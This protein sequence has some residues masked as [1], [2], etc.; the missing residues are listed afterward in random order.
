MAAE[1]TRTKTAQVGSCGEPQMVALLCGLSVGCMCAGNTSTKK[2]KA[3]TRLENKQLVLDEVNKTKHK[4]KQILLFKSFFSMMAALASIGGRS[5]VSLVILAVAL[6]LAVSIVVVAVGIPRIIVAIKADRTG[7]V[8]SAVI[9][10][11]MAA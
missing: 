7:V 9:G 10:A 11:I 6:V 2:N 4:E 3:Q 8:V 1:G 5:V